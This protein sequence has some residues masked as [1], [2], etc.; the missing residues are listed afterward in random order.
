M[1]G[2]LGTEHSAMLQVRAGAAG[3]LGLAAGGAARGRG[4]RAGAGGC[5]VHPA[6]QGTGLGGGKHGAGGPV[7]LASAG[8]C[9][10]PS[11]SP[12]VRRTPSLDMFPLE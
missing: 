9:G 12:R 3:W 11:L 4:D 10:T 5:P 8:G 2:G 7:C 6:H 1:A